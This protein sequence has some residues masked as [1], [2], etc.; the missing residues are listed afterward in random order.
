MK[1]HPT[2]TRTSPSGFSAIEVVLTI[3]VFA[4]L[5][6]VVRMRSSHL[7]DR[8]KVTSIIQAAGELKSACVLFHT[9]TARYARHAEGE[10]TLFQSP[11]EG[12]N[13]P[14]LTESKTR[15]EKHLGA[16]RLDNSHGGFE[17]TT[18]WDLDGDGKEET[19]GPCNV[20]CLTGIDRDLAAELD[21][22]Y[23]PGRGKVWEQAGRFQYVPS[24]QSALIFLHR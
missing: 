14:Y 7:L 1:T 15:L 24:T 13:G 11:L 18:G 16:W 3:V 23:D 20:L 6:G 21:R 4:I 10:E 8:S 17:Q 22:Y 12:W 9:D 2:S 5:M 19:A